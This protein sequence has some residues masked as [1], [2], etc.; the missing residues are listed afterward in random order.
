MRHHFSLLLIITCI[1]FCLPAMAQN[2]SWETYNQAGDNAIAKKQ[3][4]EAEEAYRVALKLSEKFKEKDPRTALSLIKLAE[5]LNHQ[6]KRE[7][8]EALVN[9]AL[10]ALEKA[11]A[12]SKAKDLSEEYYKRETSAMIL[13]KAADIL[14]ANQKYSE[15]EPIYKRV[16]E[17]REE[18]A[19]TK[20]SPK[21][22]EDFLRFLSQ[23]VT[24]AQATLADAY[25]KLATLYFTQRRFEEAELFYVK[26]LKSVEME[27]GAEQPATAVSLSRLATLY[28]V[29]SRYEKAE[30]LYSRAVSIFEKSNWMDKPEAARTLENYSVL[31]RKTGREAEATVILEK[32]K[33]I[34]LQLQRNNN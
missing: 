15:A 5:S 27:F 8:A 25:D 30:P 9:R 10:A 20:E 7:E 29:Q 6:Q 33:A 14:V 18:G 17:L 4:M 16:I 34:H 31:L 13:N 26:A 22:N 32:A 11:V 2:A 19:K 28:A 23:A 1:G 12:G 21:S 24:N 3:Y